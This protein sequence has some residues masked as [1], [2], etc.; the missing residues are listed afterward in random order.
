MSGPGS[1]LS[2]LFRALKAPA[3]AR[4]L[5]KLAERARAEEWSYE[6]FAATLLK[7]EIDSRESHGGQA[8]IKAARFPAHKT[9]EEFDFSFQR[10][11]KR[12]EVLHL[13][14][15]DFLNGREN[16]VL[17]G[18]PGTG[19][20]HLAIAIGI[21]ACLAGQR[22]LFKTATEWVAHLADAQRHGRLDQEL[23]RLQRIPLLLCDEV[24]Y[25]PFDPQ[26]ANLMFML[27]SRRYE[28]ASLIVTSNKP[29]S[30]WGEVF[31]DEV[32]ATAMIDRLV[33]HA[34]ILSLK[35]DSYRLRDRELARPPA[36]KVAETG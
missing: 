8:R 9:L 13:G 23:D 30:L 16:V 14:Q 11:I 36:A 15:L 7:S 27:V 28:R 31:G 4:A 34:A 35:G 24:G 22:V 12:Q 26:A 33:H 10:S 29:F 3:A 17:L 21:R 32:T 18:P 20:S 6:R 5:P 1:E 2:H 25:I 19:K